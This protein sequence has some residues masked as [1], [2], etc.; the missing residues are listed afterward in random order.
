M[1]L[2]IN[3]LL[4]LD[5]SNLKIT[6]EFLIMGMI[7]MFIVM[8]VLYLVIKILNLTDDK[9]KME[10]VKNFFKRTWSLIIGKKKSK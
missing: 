2:A 3:T 7:V 9:A 10:K 8:F 5:T 1:M 6:L 4:A